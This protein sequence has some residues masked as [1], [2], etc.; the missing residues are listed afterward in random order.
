MLLE[1]TG[2]RKPRISMWLGKI[3]VSGKKTVFLRVKSPDK[4]VGGFKILL[5]GGKI[6]GR[7]GNLACFFSSEKELGSK[8]TLCQKNHEL[9]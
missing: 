9:T 7:L 3:V 1:K 8:K 5:A 6:G 2:F 4:L